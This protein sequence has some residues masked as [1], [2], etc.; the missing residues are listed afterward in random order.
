MAM[1]EIVLRFPDHDEVRLTDRDGCRP[2]DELTIA[3]RR[4]VV[5]AT[6]EPRLAGAERRFILEPLA[7][8]Q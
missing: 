7:G 6:E 2:G 3:H 8:Q 4:F 1:F 5:T